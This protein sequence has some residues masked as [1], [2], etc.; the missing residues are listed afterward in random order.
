VKFH[1]AA[2]ILTWCLLVAIMQF[3][4][5]ETLLISAGFVF[6]FALLLSARKFFQL[7]R[8]TRWILLSLLLIYA[9]TTPGQPLLDSLGMF[10]PSREGLGDGVLQLARL[11]AAIACLAILLE[12]LNRQ[13]LIAGLYILLAPLQFIGVSRERVAVRLAL[14]LHYAEVAMLRE[15]RTWQEH[16][17]SLFEPH[18][19]TGKKIELPLYRFGVCDGLLVG[20]A[21][22]LLYETM[23]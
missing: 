16:L 2:Q 19:E 9:Y 13:Q 20:F 3:L 15:T 14:T 5:F 1:P 8:R 10:S 4:A 7:L 23:K 11:M 18:G 17:H 22:L 12:R 6:L 21:L